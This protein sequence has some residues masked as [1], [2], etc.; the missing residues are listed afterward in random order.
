MRTLAKYKTKPARHS[1]RLLLELE[2]ELAL[3]GRLFGKESA[4]VVLE[5]D[6][7]ASQNISPENKFQ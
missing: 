6:S 3:K 7:I 4:L 5:L 1:P 2:H